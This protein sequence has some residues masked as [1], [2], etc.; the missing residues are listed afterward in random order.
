MAG[1]AKKLQHPEGTNIGAP[2]DLSLST[3]TTTI[4][5]YANDADY[6][7][8]NGAPSNG[9][10]YVNT[11][12]RTFKVYA[13]GAWRQ[14]WVE[15]DPADAT[16]LLVKD[17]SGQATGVT[18]TIGSLA[19]ADRTQ[20]LP[21]K[22]GEFA[23]WES[24]QNLNAP[25][26]G[27]ATIGGN[28][29]AN[30]LTLGG[31]STTTV[32]PGNLQVQGTTTQVDTTNMN[33]K[34]QNILI[35]DGGN[36]ASA[37]GAGLTVERTGT[38]GSLVYEDALASKFKGGAL[39]SESEFITAT[40]VQTVENKR[41]RLETTVAGNNT[42][43]PRLI[44]PS[45][46]LANLQ[47]ISGANHL[48][49]GAVYWAT[50]VNRA[51]TWNGTALVP[52]GSGSGSGTGSVNFFENTDFEATTDGVSAYDDG[53]AV[54]V[55]GSGG[56]PT[57]TFARNTTTPLNGTSDLMLSKG[58]SDCQ[59]QGWAFDAPVP[60]GYRYAQSAQV[61]FLWDSLSE[62][63]YVAG[64]YKVY[65]YDVLNSAFITPRISDLP[66]KFIG[67]FRTYFDLTDS[68]E[69]RV[70]IHVASTNANAMDVYVDDFII[71][72]ASAAPR[73]ATQGDWEQVDLTYNGLGTIVS[74][75]VIM[76]QDGPDLEMIGHVVAGTLSGSVTGGLL[77]PNNLE[78]DTTDLS[79]TRQHNFGNFNQL[80]TATTNLTGSTYAGILTWASGNDNE[81]I[82]TTNSENQLYDGDV[83]NAVLSAGAVFSF[84]VRVPIRQWR[85]INTLPMTVPD[86]EYVYNTDLANANDLTSF[87]Y[88]QDGS[89]FGNFSG[90]GPT[91][92][93][94]FQTPIKPTDQ[95]DLEVS[96]NSGIT[97]QSLQTNNI[98]SS[99]QAQAGTGYGINLD[100]VSGSSTQMDLTF[101]NHRL[102]NAAT[103]GGSGSNWS[104][105]DND[106]QFR[107][108]VKKVSKGLSV[109]VERASETHSGTVNPYVEGDGV[110]YAGKYTPTLTAGTGISSVTLTAAHYMRVGKIVHVSIYGAATSSGPVLSLINATLPIASDLTLASDVSGTCGWSG[111]A[112]VGAGWVE[113]DTA[114]NSANIRFNQTNNAAGEFG[115]SF[116]YEIK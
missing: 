9:A 15:Q 7:T 51:Y 21:D 11:T 39:G 37:E 8:A 111:A 5:A 96:A 65:I 32:I 71:G 112:A 13:N 10:V 62:T 109:G 99:Y 58:A 41:I 78:V 34:D 23:M 47:A 54:P 73:G 12:T 101:G 113:A 83:A 64:D 110:V 86:I 35:N 28:V 79:E 55:D 70:L 22:A 92:R 80:F 69:Y 89:Q 25:A 17:L 88:G 67:T 59:G 97:W 40:H 63:N 1:T 31:A 53:S 93:V 60:R 91:K 42:T 20:N 19:T 77:L 105:I 26:A 27:N 29:G 114:L 49:E 104:D 98:V 106:P 43:S 16:K 100:V 76:R 45:N 61:A 3:S 2:T 18:V 6:A 115:C 33:V 4:E 85:G 75:K 87:G 90:G 74:Q 108:R 50:D 103:F 30:N 94:Q 116:M 72:P 38:N 95:I 82:F 81:L 14:C 52:L 46:T 68:D 44:L 56:S 48:S 66:Q 84:R 24:G 107:W 36:D 57:V 102:A